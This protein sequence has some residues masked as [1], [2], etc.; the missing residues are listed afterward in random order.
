MTLF[1]P[2]CSNNNWGSTS[3][4]IRFL[5][6]LV[7]EGFSGMCHKVS[8]GS[9]YEDPYW[10]PVQQWCEQNNLPVIGYHYVTT[11]DP[12]AQVRTWQGNGGGTL[13]ML[14]WEE[15]GGNLTNLTGVVE[16]FHAAGI[17]VQ[18]GYY[19]QWYWNQEGAGN[20]SQ[21][22]NAL[23][24]SA[25]PDGSGYASTIYTNSGGNSGAGWAPY[26]G[27][28]PSAWQF[29][30]SANIAGFQVDCNAYRGS[31]IKVLFGTAPTPTASPPLD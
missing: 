20:L 18:L 8:E 28:T 24:A 11:D 5:E 2:D 26:G 16:A 23:V 25:Y 15:N 6:Q 4:A 29:T 21:L 3:D 31:D 22:A 30:S 27:T 13:A 1:Y 12:A 17:T 9:Y 7:P 14:D 19:P 10:P